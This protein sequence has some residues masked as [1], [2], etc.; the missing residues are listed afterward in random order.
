MRATSGDAWFDSDVKARAKPRPPL[1]SLLA[2]QRRSQSS[3]RLLR[4]NSDAVAQ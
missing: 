3:D 2:H 4:S 1:A